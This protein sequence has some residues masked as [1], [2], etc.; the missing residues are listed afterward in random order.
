MN[1]EKLKALQ[2][3]VRIGG[4]VCFL[5]I[6]LGPV[7]IYCCYKSIFLFSAG[8]CSEKEEGSSQNSSNWW[9]ETERKAT[10]GTL[11]ALSALHVF[12]LSFLFLF[13]SYR[14]IQMQV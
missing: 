14:I 2:E 1:P 4:K 5:S 11:S 9:K 8:Y 3:G 12:I 6:I 10:G 13:A 7:E